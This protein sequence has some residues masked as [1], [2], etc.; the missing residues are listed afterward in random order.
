MPALSDTSPKTS[1]S[2]SSD[3][4]L[5]SSMPILSGASLPEKHTSPKRKPHRKLSTS[6]S[7]QDPLQQKT[8]GKNTSSEVSLDSTAQQNHS[9]SSP[10]QKKTSRSNVPQA[11]TSLRLSA[12]PT[13]RESAS[14]SAPA[15][16]P[17]LHKPAPREASHPD[18]DLIIIGSGPAALT[19]AVYARRAGL[20]V[21]IYER[22]SIGGTLNEISDLENF[23]GFEGPGAELAR[24]MRQQ[25]ERY[26]V[27]I[28]YGECTEVRRSA[29]GCELLV[30]GEKATARSILIATGAAPRRLDLPMNGEA[31]PFSYCALCDGALAQGK[32]VAMIGG[33]NAAVQEALYLADLAKDVVLITHSELK[34]DQYLQDLLRR[35]ENIE[36]REN[37]EPTAKMLRAF[38]HV[39]V[40]I[41][42]RPSSEC[43]RDLAEELLSDRGLLDERGYILTNED[44]EYPHQT[45]A[46]GIFAAGDVRHG[47]VQQ[48][49]TAAGE[50][51][52]AAIEIANWLKTDDSGIFPQNP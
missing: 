13:S 44:S 11:A 14:A 1:P 32:R 48:A 47:A 37:V 26:G 7:H 49:V 5:K 6:D 21:K 31:P 51:A 45:V 3:A 18:A 40:A 41:G 12:K 39:F 8:H 17:A 16:G 15:H 36:V 42:K 10:S 50:G 23:P 35:A 20:S 24:T 22:A 19:A 2:T 46:P 28:R 9:S 43:L 38:D 25:A 33:A 29:Q 30:D 27:E 4:P 34:A 52:A